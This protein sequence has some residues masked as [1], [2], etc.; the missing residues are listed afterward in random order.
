MMA[1]SVLIVEDEW[2]IAEDEAET[3]RAAGYGIVGPCASVGAALAAID[4]HKV[5]A[6]FLD[7]ELRNERSYPVAERLSALG[8]PFCFVSG[9]E[10]PD[11]PPGVPNA[12]LKPT[13]P[14]A[15]LAA[16][17]SMTSPGEVRA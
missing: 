3:L 13:E 6:A 9:Y 4:E 10:A 15:L 11:L 2:L 1:H 12:L 5:D 16:A 17:A 7:V 14:N 8:I